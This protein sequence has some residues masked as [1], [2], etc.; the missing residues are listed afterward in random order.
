MC[1]SRGAVVSFKGVAQPVNIKPEEKHLVLV[2]GPEP[3]RV[4]Q[5]H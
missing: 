4:V 2:S 3:G 5:T 1:V